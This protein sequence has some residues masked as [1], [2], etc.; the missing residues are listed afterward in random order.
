MFN[1]LIQ[2]LYLNRASGRETI[3]L[4]IYKRGIHRTVRVFAYK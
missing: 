1:V 2:V 3:L 4:K